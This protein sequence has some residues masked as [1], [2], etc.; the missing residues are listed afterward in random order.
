MIAEI[1]E[2][3]PAIRE[4]DLEITLCSSS[5]WEARIEWQSRE[6]Y[7]TGLWN[8]L[9]LGVFTEPSGSFSSMILRL[10]PC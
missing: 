1:H 4:S 8:A 7:G 3:K 6:G 5:E 10:S 9:T 2:F